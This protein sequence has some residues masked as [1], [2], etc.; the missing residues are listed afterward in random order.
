MKPTG[1]LLVNLGTPEEP[2]PSAVRRFLREFLSDRRVV[3]LPRLVWLPILYLLVLPFRPR[4]VAKK[5]A[6]IWTRDG[7]PLR[8]YLGRQA[9]LLRGYL[10]ER[11]KAPMPVAGAMRYGKPAVA[12]GFEELRARGC[13]R[14]LVVPLYPQYSVSA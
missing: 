3:E 8:V 9:Q 6:S 2:T 10:G 1:V 7:S 12:E 4:K 13:E 5:Y 11:L 14:V